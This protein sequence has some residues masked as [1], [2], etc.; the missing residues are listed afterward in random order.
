MSLG[1]AAKFSA[2]VMRHL[3]NTSTPLFADFAAFKRYF[4]TNFCPVDEEM[5]AALALHDDQY[6]QGKRSVDE[7]VD[8][9]TDLLEDAGMSDG[10]NVVLMFKKGLDAGIRRRIAEMVDGRPNDKK[11]AEWIL[12]TQQIER[13]TMADKK[14]ASIV[15][16]PT[17]T[18]SQPAFPTRAPPAPTMT[19][20]PRGMW[21]LPTVS[22]TPVN[23][24]TAAT[25][26]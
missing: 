14:F 8:E 21:Q 18:T 7:Y 25:L 12:A 11:L 13:N 22:T 5:T 20:L 6:F 24:P 17:N 3:S 1:R 4:V 2:R 26:P 23:T 16:R 19:L 9:F 15:N 10:L